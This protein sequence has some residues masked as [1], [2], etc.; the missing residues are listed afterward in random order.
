MRFQAVI[1]GR[2]LGEI[3]PKNPFVD[4]QTGEVSPVKRKMALYQD[5]NEFPVIVQIPDDYKVI[6]DKEVQIPVVISNWSMSGKS[7]ILIKF[8]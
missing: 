8:N 2:V 6:K 4:K 1:S 7:G 3:K 5:G